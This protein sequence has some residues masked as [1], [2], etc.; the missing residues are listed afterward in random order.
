MGLHA[1]INHFGS[2][3]NIA[4]QGTIKKAEI[5]QI[6]AIVRHFQNQGC[7]TIRFDLSQTDVSSATAKPFPHLSYILDRPACGSVPACD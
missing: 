2:E 6:E 5:A 4:I 7:R 1:Q 3:V